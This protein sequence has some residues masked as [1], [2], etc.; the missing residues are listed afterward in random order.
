MPT[1]GYFG[2]YLRIDLSDGRAERV[3]IAET[4]LREHLGGSGLGV[5]SCS[6]KEAPRPIRCRRKR[7][8]SSS[9]ARSSAARS[10]RPP[11][12]PSSARA[13][14][15]SGSTIRW[16]AA[17]SRWPAS[18]AATTPSCS[19]AAP[20]SLG[21]GHRRRR[22]ARWNPPDDVCGAACGVAEETLR[23]RLGADYRIA[24]IGP[25]GER[26]VRYATISHD[27]RHAGRGGSGAVLGSKN[28]KAIAVRGTQRAEW[29]HPDELV[30]LSQRPV[31]AIVRP[32]DGEIPRA[33]HRHEP[34]RRSTASARCRRATSSSGSFD[35][36][37][38]AVSPEQLSVVAHA[39]ARASCVACTI[40]C[41]HIYGLET[42]AAA[43]GWNT[44]TCSRS[45]RLCGVDDPRRRAACVAA[46]RRAG[47]RHD[48]RRR[49]DRVRHG[50]RRARAARRAVAR[51]GN[52]DAVLRAIDLIVRREGV[53]TSAGRRQPARGRDDRRRQHRVR[54]AGQG[55]RDPRLRAA[56]A[57]DDGAGVRRGRPRR[58]PQ[59][60]RGLRGGLLGQGRSP[61]RDAGSVRAG[62]RNR[63]QGR[64]DGLA[65][66]LQVPPRRVHRFLRRGR[67]DAAG[68]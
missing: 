23:A 4:V 15:P 66:S 19:W 7:R 26:A 57:A 11:S 3:P 29:A 48:Q 38:A 63:R 60:Q 10:P 39:R 2:S 27:G 56:R 42:A 50:V 65:D 44:K 61:Q 14:S 58:R 52:G 64:A 30:A 43:C 33:G 5:V 41:E 8:W 32:G 22:R 21:P 35:R 25:A 51:F 9:S 59:P 67:Q 13:R 12:S 54:A 18:A 49:H 28:I 45:A 46:L 37:R 40:G 24:S 55:P 62:D 36:G 47:H 6:M 17:A 68:W 53:G 1:P 31:E 16:P 34:A 20:P